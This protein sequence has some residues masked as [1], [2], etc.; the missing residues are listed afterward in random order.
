MASISDD[1][2]AGALVYHRFPAGKEIQPTK[3]LATNATGAAYS[4]G[5]ARLRAHR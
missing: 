1:L 2:S 5:V 3:P 4:P